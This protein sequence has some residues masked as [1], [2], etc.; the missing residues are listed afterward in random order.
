[1]EASHFCQIIFLIINWISLSESQKLKENIYT[2][3]KNVRPCFR[4]L[5][6][7][8]VIGCTSEKGGNVGVLVYVE[9][10]QDFESVITESKDFA[11]F[12]V[13]VDPH[14]Y[15]GEL[16]HKLNSSGMVN[17]VLL[18]TVKDG[19]WADHFPRRGFSDDARCPDSFLPDNRA[20]C[21]SRSPWNPSGSGV[22]W[23][24][25][26]FPIFLLENSTFAQDIHECYDNHNIKRP[27]H[28]PLCALELSSNMY[29]AKDS[30]TCL[31]RSSLFNLSPVSRC[32]PLSDDNIHYFVSPRLETEASEEENSVILVT[33][34]MDTLTM[35]DQV[36][37][38][39]DSPSSGIVTLLAVAESL[40][41]KIKNL[42]FRNGIQN[43][44]FLLIQGES[45][46]FIGSTRLIDDMLNLSFPFNNS[47]DDVM[48]KYPNGSQ[49]VFKLS[50]VHSVIEID[51]VSNAD[52]DQLYLHTS[53][54]PDEIVRTLRANAGGLQVSEVTN[55][56]PPA[57][58]VTILR[59]RPEIP[60]VVVTNYRNQFSNPM[61]HSIYDTAARA[62]Y[63]YSREHKVV[64]H[65]AS[66]TEM[67]TNAVMELATGQRG[68]VIPGG[69]GETEDLVNELLNCYT[70]TS[71]CSK[72]YEA[73][74]P[75]DYPWNYIPEARGITPFPQYVGVRS[76]YHTLMTRRVLQLI[77]GQ[78]VQVTKTE[79][80]VTG[81][82]EEDTFTQVLGEMKRCRD[83]NKDQNIFR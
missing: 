15:S 53:N 7:T 20:L 5:N 50:S 23:E 74:T 38:G 46:D 77:T 12:I 60:T 37:T 76:S 69:R 18:P 31:R 72:F 34:K 64:G 56:L 54:S 32:D 33:A 75:D 1:M 48:K 58:S 49:P 35:F 22:M 17:G 79:E 3:I 13:L 30:E 83:L 43:I 44:L 68:P 27:L 61:Y 63:N 57:S 71:N 51:Q 10:E 42:P 62:G 4:R 2:E 26:A 78:P 24:Q 52:S 25:W 81:E 11:P 66:L 8:N 19:K 70:L 45:F 82:E 67:V 41:K 80:S 65:L 36:E 9:S 6:G 55:S 40:T 73:S 47:D 39:F 21:S 28:W 16:L 14:I 59:A 29:A